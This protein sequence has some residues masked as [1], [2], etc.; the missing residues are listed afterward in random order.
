[1]ITFKVKESIVRKS[2]CFSDLH[3]CLLKC[4][5][6]KHGNATCRLKIENGHNLLIF[7]KHARNLCSATSIEV[8]I[9]PE[10]N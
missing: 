9:E 6:F 7:R 1:M 5:H 2:V 4:T 10:I 3:A 8:F